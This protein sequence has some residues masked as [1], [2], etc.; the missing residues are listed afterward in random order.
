[1]N[2]LVLYMVL[3]GERTQRHLDFTECVTITHFII[4]VR[5]M[6]RPPFAY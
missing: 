1:M 6:C 2:G 5:H 3:K 4:S